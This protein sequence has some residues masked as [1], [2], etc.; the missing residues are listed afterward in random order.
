MDIDSSSNY[1]LYED[2]AA[3]ELQRQE[4]IQR[5]TRDDLLYKQPKT[6]NVDNNIGDNS[7]GVDVPECVMW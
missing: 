6:I 3:V 1:L 4:Q 2:N 5:Y 7:I